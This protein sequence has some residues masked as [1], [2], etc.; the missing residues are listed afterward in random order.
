M[1]KYAPIRSEQNASCMLEFD[2]SVELRVGNDEANAMRRSYCGLRWRE[3]NDFI[4][5]SRALFYPFFKF[6]LI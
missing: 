1:E 3:N 6:A 2:A 4:A 5:K